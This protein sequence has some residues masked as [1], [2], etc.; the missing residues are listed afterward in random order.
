MI[1]E[2]ESTRTQ[3]PRSRSCSA[4]RRDGWEE[5]KHRGGHLQLRHPTKPGCVTI[6]IHANP[7]HR[8]QTLTSGLKQA[9]LSFAELQDL[10]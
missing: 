2:D 4:L 3:D 1:L 9:G 6:A 10:L 8:H 5:A 7:R